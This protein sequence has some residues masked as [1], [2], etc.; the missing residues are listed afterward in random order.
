MRDIKDL[1]QAKEAELKQLENEVEVL[2]QAVRLLEQQPG[3]RERSS[4]P[5]PRLREISLP[6]IAVDLPVASPEA[7]V[8]S[9]LLEE[10]GSEAS[11]SGTITSR[12][13]P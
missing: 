2:R 7:T 12:Q 8:S 6:A 3:P 5:E 9:L 1:L 11:S 13:F 4:Y 10:H